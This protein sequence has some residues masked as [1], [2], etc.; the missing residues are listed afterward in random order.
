[1]KYIHVQNILRFQE[2]S[3]FFLQNFFEMHCFRSILFFTFN[4][5]I[6]LKLLAR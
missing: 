6:F 5:Y 1:M 4:T 3:I 2:I